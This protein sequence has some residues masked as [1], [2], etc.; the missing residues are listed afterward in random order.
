MKSVICLIIAAWLYYAEGKCLLKWRD[1]FDAAIHAP[2]RVGQFRPDD[3]DNSRLDD[4]RE[5]FKTPKAKAEIAAAEKYLTAAK[6]C[7][8]GSIVFV[9]LVV[10]LPVLHRLHKR[11]PCEASESLSP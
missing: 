9:I 6:L 3:P 5:V 11:P 1:D 10:A 2:Q 4:P 8:Y 7:H